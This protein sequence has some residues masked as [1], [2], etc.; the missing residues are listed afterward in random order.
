MF[1]GVMIFII[2][3]QTLV[4]FGYVVGEGFALAFDVHIEGITGT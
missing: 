4:M 3:L 2:G 1:I